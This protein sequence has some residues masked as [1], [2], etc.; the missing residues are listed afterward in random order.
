[1]LARARRRLGQRPARWVQG[2]LRALPFEPEQ[3]EAVFHFGVLHCIEEAQTV[4]DEL[5]RVTQSGGK[6]F[7]SCLTLAR[8]RGDAFLRRLARAGHVAAPRSTE[9][10]VDLVEGAG[11]TLRAHTQRGSF[12]FIEAER[13]AS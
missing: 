5:A 7:L 8:P 6:L 12:L 1:M 3:F 4:L 2:D 11:F 9:Q 13:T 10:V